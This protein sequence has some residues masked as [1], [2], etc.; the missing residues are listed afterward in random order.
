M[1]TA[2]PLRGVRIVE[3]G[4]LIAI[5]YAIKLL[6]DMGAQVMRIEACARLEP[7]RASSFYENDPRGEYWNRGANFYE[8]NRNKLG[9]TL[10]LGKPQGIDAL[11]ELIAVSD[12]FVENFTPRVMKNFGLEYEDVRRVRPDII[13]VSSTGYGYT[14][15]W[16][17]FGAIAYSTEAATGLAYMTGY[18]GGPPAIPDMPHTDF[19]AA[20]HTAFAIMAALI[21]RARTGQ[22]Q[23]IDVSQAQTVSS[24]I[25]E[26]LMD[27]AGNGRIQERMGNQHP[28]MAPHG[29]YPCRGKD[30]WIALAIATDAQWGALCHVLG[31]PAWSDGQRFVDGPSRRRHRN[32][33]DRLLGEA[34]KEWDHYGLMHS[35]QRRGVPAGAVLSN[36]ELLTDPHLEARRFFETTA[37]HPSTGIPPLPYPGRPWKMSQTPGGT[38]SP[39]PLL[40]EHNHLVLSELLGMSDAKIDGLLDQGII[41]RQPVGA[42]P[43]SVIS[44]EDQKRHGSILD[45]DE[46]FKGWLREKYGD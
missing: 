14:G 22:G 42:R 25:P 26:A 16:A 3:M 38:R 24:T 43:P 4:Q 31:R 20:E 10:D 12:V 45:Y 37:H 23:F 7:Y 15:P 18:K 1:D 44:L 21:H 2:L 39:A 32:E 36:K 11:E 40:G 8:Q 17:G 41:G 19:V 5:P 46:D 35:L 30:Q 34:T 6:G 27:Y 29:C 9:L 13:M 28:T 33:L